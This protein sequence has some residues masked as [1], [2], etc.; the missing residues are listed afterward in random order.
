MKKIE[1]VEQVN[2]IK[3]RLEFFVKKLDEVN[4][5]HFELQEIDDL[6]SLL[7]ELEKKCGELLQ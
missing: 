6:I 4:P 2:E 3:D 5:E 7:D 1:K